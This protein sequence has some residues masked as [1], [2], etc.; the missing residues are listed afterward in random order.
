MKRIACIGTCHL[1]Q[2]IF[3]DA[4]AEKGERILSKIVTGYGG[5][6]R[7]TAQNLALIGFPVT[8]AT[9][10]GNDMDSVNIWNDCNALGIDVLG[11][12]V[13]LPTPK[14]TVWIP[15]DGKTTVFWDK[16]DDFL[17]RAGDDIPHPAIN[18]CDIAVTD[19]RDNAALLKMLE[20]SPHP[21][22]IVSHYV[23][24]KEILSHVWGL[25]I[26]YEDALSLGKPA[27]FERICYR[28]CAFG[29]E[30]IVI[31]MNFQGV[32]LYTKQTGTNFLT[33]CQGEGYINGCYS[34]FLSGLVA[35]LAVTDDIEKAV[36]VGLTAQGLTYKCDA[37]IHPRIGELFKKKT[38]SKG[39]V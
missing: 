39:A 6:M 1:E 5:T 33:K 3:T 38:K 28:L 13:D 18:Q 21:R 9:K 37:L 29:P 12:T 11:P 8:Y 16:P 27:D 31:N 23:P 34:A 22:W 19:V 26:N 25:V 10:L 17:F 32:Y 24:D 2:D 30:W 4:S 15:K 20:K 7:N 36:L 35:S 14:K